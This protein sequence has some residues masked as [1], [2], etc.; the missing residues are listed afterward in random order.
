MFLCSARNH[1]EDQTEGS[2]AQKA[3][4][5]VGCEN[6]NWIRVAQDTVQC[7]ALGEHANDICRSIRR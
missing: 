4:I 1:C 6:V 2:E 7:C 5:C 3:F